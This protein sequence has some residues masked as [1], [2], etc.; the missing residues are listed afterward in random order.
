MLRKKKNSVCLQTQ[1]L[2]D[3]AHL[4]KLRR[5]GMWQGRWNCLE[6]LSQDSSFPP[7]PHTVHK[8]PS[9]QF[10]GPSRS[11]SPPTHRL[12]LSLLLWSRGVLFGLWSPSVFWRED[13]SSSSWLVTGVSRPGWS[14]VLSGNLV[15]L[16]TWDWNPE[17]EKTL[18]E[19]ATN[20]C[21]LKRSSYN[22][23]Y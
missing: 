5:A 15:L 20:S 11:S 3:K 23:S 13:M 21:F 10:N 22:H 12:W 17:R 1:I 9:E 2:P 14:P 6:H 4:G 18:S 8:P 16:L 7:V 19:L